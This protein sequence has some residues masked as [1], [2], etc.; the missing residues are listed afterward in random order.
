MNDLP[1]S[2]W[3]VGQKATDFLREN[4]YNGEIKTFRNS[5]EL[6]DTYQK[7]QPGSAVYYG[8]ER[9]SQDWAEH[10]ITHVITYSNSAKPPRLA[11]QQWNAILAFS[12][13][14]VQSALQE[15]DFPKNTPVVCIGERTA[16]AI[17]TH[18]FS[19]VI[20]APKSDFTTLL[21]TLKTN[22]HDK[23]RPLSSH[24]QRRNDRA[25]SS[26]VHAPSAVIYQITW[27]LRKNTPSLNA[28]RIRPR[29]RNHGYAYRPSGRRCCHPLF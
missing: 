29:E 21:Q 20:A 3:V 27:Y 23:K 19:N 8:A 12:P 15:N 18:D 16:E 4:S 2:T 28:Y 1:E 24:A 11:R 9:I 22:Y 10:G 13:L 7:E 26:M 5:G 6:V 25:S 14:G 17:K